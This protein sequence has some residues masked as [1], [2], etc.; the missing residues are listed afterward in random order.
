ME[1]IEVQI[2]HLRLRLPLFNNS[3]VS[4]LMPSKT[5]N[6]SPIFTRPPELDCTAVAV[7][8]SSPFSSITTLAFS[9][10][11]C[12][13]T[14][15][16]CRSSLASPRMLS[17]LNVEWLNSWNKIFDVGVTSLKKNKKIQNN[18]CQQQQHETMSITGL[19]SRSPKQD[20]VCFWWFLFSGHVSHQRESQ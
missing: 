16:L 4:I 5:V 19:M 1:Q 20:C 18:I 15:C 11:P 3:F 13:R 7:G 9:N 17:L 12:S 8:L 14:S 6:S 10:L 2:N